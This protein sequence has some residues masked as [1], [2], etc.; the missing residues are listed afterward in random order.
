MKVFGMIGASGILAYSILSF[1]L[2]CIDRRRKK[3]RM[4]S[5]LKDYKFLLEVQV[6]Q[7]LQ[8]G[9]KEVLVYSPELLANQLIPKPKSF[10]WVFFVLF[11]NFFD[12]KYN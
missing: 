8:R 7:N 9:K 5:S 2:M 12:E 10:S 11:V 6:S 1:L 4:A 3:R